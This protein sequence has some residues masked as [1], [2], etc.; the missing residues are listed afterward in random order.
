[1]LSKQVK[2]RLKHVLEEEREKK[3]KG[4]KR[5]N[6][7][8]TDDTTYIRTLNESIMYRKIARDVCARCVYNGLLNF[9]DS[10]FRMLRDVLIRVG[11]F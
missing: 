6:C 5:G 8:R 11:H 4:K 9:R 1:M 10:A 2:F 7:A 3:K